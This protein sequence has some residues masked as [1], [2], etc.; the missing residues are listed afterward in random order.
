V[1]GVCQNSNNTH[2]CNDGVYCN[3]ADTCSNGSCSDH[4]GDPCA[5][6]GCCDE[7]NNDCDLAIDSS[8]PPDGAIDARRTMDP[9]GSNPTGW[10]SIDLTMT[11]V[12]GPIAA[13][14]FTVTVTDGTPPDITGVSVSQNVVTLE[15]DAFIPPGEWTQF[16]HDCS[17]TSVCLGYLPADVENDAHSGADDIL[18][19]IDCLNDVET[20]ET[21][22]CDVD[23]SDV[24]G[25]PD[26]LMVIDLLNG[27]G[28]YDPWSNVS[29]DE[30]PCGGGGESAMAGEQDVARAFLVLL[31][32]GP[33]SEDLADSD[34]E[35][36]VR[37]LTDWLVMT[38]PERE[39]SALAAYL[40][41]VSLAFANSVV[42][43]MIPETTATLRK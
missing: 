15:L 32:E 25:A 42:R 10:D 21:W 28:V 34:I 18:W 1:S 14:D 43:D 30:N 41:D 16:S 7:T 9:D 22:Q 3:G 4:N 23:R 29:L 2:S 20:C 26:V 6:S 12:P 36:I 39:R 27:A 38:L 24:C 40:Q 17:E 19:L 31:T 5:G 35:L 13:E 8:S 37:A 11:G 33:W